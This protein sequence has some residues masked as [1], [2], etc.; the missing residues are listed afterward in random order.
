M[1]PEYSYNEIYEL[2]KKRAKLLSGRTADMFFNGLLPK[3]VGYTVL[4][5]ADI[6]LTSCVGNFTDRNLKNLADIVYGFKISVSGNNGL[7]NAQVSV[8][9]ISTDDFN[10]DTMESKLTK[11]VYAIGEVLDIDG[12]CG[13]FNLQWAWSSA[14][15]AAQAIIGKCK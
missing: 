1:L 5:S 7:D 4:K 3:M 11:G 13:G 8:G 12:D 10:S 14:A 9:G 6:K 15:A 2:I